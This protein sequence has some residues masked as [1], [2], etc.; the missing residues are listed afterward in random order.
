MATKII[1][2]EIYLV[3]AKVVDASKAY[4]DLSGYPQSFDSHQNGDDLEK[5]MNKAYAAYENAAAS[6]HTSAASG[7]P[8]TIVSLV[9][10]SDGKQL[11]KK[12]I[13][14]MPYYEEEIPDPE[15]EPE[16]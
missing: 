11:E 13:G 7:R 16:G 5:T 3:E 6:G 1:P 9:R 4:N 15:P 10:I 14:K 8:L 12:Q 2:R